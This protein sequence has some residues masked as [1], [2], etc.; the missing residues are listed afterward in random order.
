M[1]DSK[2]KPAYPCRAKNLSTC[3]YHGAFLRLEKAIEANDYTAYETAKTE[4][5]DVQ[6][7]KRQYK[8]AETVDGSQVDR[9]TPP[10]FM[11]L[12]GRTSIIS[13]EVVGYYSKL[14]RETKQHIRSINYHQSKGEQAD[15][16]NLI[17]EK[18]LT[19]YAQTKEVQ[20]TKNKP[21]LLDT[22]MKERFALKMLDQAL[23][24]K[25]T[26]KEFEDSLE[27][28]KTQTKMDFD[29]D[30]ASLSRFAKSNGGNDM[31]L[32]ADAIN[33]ANIYNATSDMLSAL[34][35]A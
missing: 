24:T 16:R 17:S 6:K 30:W 27:R 34:R 4:V 23:K 18:V 11:W 10:K 9:I 3:P 8:K 13:G 14:H 31:Q 32:N 21:E 1:T 26:R 29:K 22:A 2:L 20:R 35:S 7:R 15:Y 33:T 19:P 25:L 12:Q 28:V 5:L